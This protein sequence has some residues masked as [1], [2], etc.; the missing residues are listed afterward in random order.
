MSSHRP[1]QP[2]QW[3]WPPPP[4]PPPCPCSGL[5]KQYH[6]QNGV[7]SFYCLIWIPCAQACDL[8]WT[9]SNVIIHDRSQPWAYGVF[10]PALGTILKNLCSTVCVTVPCKLV[11]SSRPMCKPTWAMA[12][13][14]MIAP[15]GLLGQYTN[16]TTAT[17]GDSGNP[18]QSVTKDADPQPPPIDLVLPPPAIPH[19]SV[20]KDRHAGLRNHPQPFRTH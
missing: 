8:S 4:L 14:N 11:A 3:W 17:Q 2:R 20:L 12:C 1:L 15:R 10:C 5:D 18:S 13:M 19:T 16:T 7:K 9:Y 6:T